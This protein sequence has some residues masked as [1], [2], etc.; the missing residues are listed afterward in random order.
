MTQHFFFPSAL[1]NHAGLQLGVM[2]GL[3]GPDSGPRNLVPHT[4]V[5]HLGNGN[6][7]AYLTKLLNEMGY[8]FICSIHKSE[9][10]ISIPL[11]VGKS[12]LSVILRYLHTP[13]PLPSF[14]LLNSQS[15][16]PPQDLCRCFLCLRSKQRLP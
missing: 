11:L 4:Q 8:A 3:E 14:C 10:L 2:E 15:S 16:F 7:N 6:H 13:Q 5:P 9:S 12:H 1:L